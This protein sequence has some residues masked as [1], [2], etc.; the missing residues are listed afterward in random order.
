MCPGQQPR[1]AVKKH[2]KARS[3][4][5]RRGNCGQILGSSPATKPHDARIEGFKNCYLSSE[6]NHICFHLGVGFIQLLDFFI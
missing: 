3:R 1:H 6:F 4:G 2:K 5:D